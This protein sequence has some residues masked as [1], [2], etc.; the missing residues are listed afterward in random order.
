MQSI[1][2]KILTKIKKSKKGTL[3]INADFIDFANSKAVSK[4]LERLTL[5]GKISRIARGFYTINKFSK[6]I[7]EVRPTTE[8]IALKICERDKARIMPTGPAALNALG[9]STQVPMKL[10]YLTDGSPRKIVLG[11]RSI[12]FKKTS[13]KNLSTIGPISGLVITAL[14]SIGKGL[15]YDHEIEIILKHLKNEKPQNI[16]HDIKIAPEWIRVILRK[17]LL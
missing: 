7:G 15:V 12:L 3:F 10:V 11:R 4:A 6:L 8:E 1:E 17:A 5:K 9:L 16:I 13:T 2:N 14:K